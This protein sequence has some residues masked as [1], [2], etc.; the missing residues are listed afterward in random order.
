MADPLS[1][2]VRHLR[3]FD[4]QAKERMEHLVACGQFH[5]SECGSQLEDRDSYCF[6]CFFRRRVSRP[7]VDYFSSLVSKLKAAYARLVK[8]EETCI[9]IEQ[10]HS[11]NS[12]KNPDLNLEQWGVLQA[13]HRTL[14]HEHHEHPIAFSPISPEISHLRKI[15]YDPNLKWRSFRRF[16]DDMLRLLGHE[17]NLDSE[18]QWLELINFSLSLSDILGKNDLLF[19][20]DEIVLMDTSEE[21][22]PIFRRKKIGWCWIIWIL[23]KYPNNEREKLCLSEP[24]FEFPN[25]MRHTCT[26]M[27]WTILPALLVLWGVCWM[28][29]IG[30]SQP[31]HE[32]GNAV[33]PMISPVPA[34]YDIYADSH[35]IGIEEGLQG[36]VAD[37]F[38]NRGYLSQDTLEELWPGDDQL[39]NDLIHPLTFAQ[40]TPQDPNF[41][42]PDMTSRGDSDS[43]ETAAQDTAE[44]AAAAA[45]KDSTPTACINTGNSVDRGVTGSGDISGYGHQ[46]IN[47]DEAEETKSSL[48]CLECQQTFARPFTLKRHQTEKHKDASILE[49]SLLCPNTG[50]KRSN[51]KPFKRRAHLKGHLENCKHNQEDLCLRGDQSCPRSA[52]AST[53]ASASIQHRQYVEPDEVI[54]ANGVKKRPRAEDDEGSNDEFLLAEMVKKQKKMEKE[55]REKQEGKKALEKTIQMLKDSLRNS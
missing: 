39:M 46:T 9:Q 13:I 11:R 5:C 55:I 54:G 30:S 41:L 26:T 47:S 17:Q 49:E 12:E 16:S 29:I 35:G 50:C 20:D 14:S 36:S 24:I 6:H 25:N 37:G 3:S 34:A 21:K 43:L 28:F 38:D 2:W 40:N 32:W 8:A 45:M 31:E 52:S 44:I 4:R 23:L 1:K 48:V 27:P 51:E 10:G 15:A 22:E 7:P 53:S 42:I 18:R 19:F 33:D